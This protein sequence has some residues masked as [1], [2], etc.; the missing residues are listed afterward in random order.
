MTAGT[1]EGLA[2]APGIGPASR[3]ACGKPAWPRKPSSSAPPCFCGAGGIY[4]RLY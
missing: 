4:Q 3:P 1:L 2:F